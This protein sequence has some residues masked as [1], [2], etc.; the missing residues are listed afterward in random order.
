MRCFRT[1]SDEVYEQARLA[2]D[3]AWG[4]P[5]SATKTVT[6]IDP[7]GVATRDVQGRIMLAVQDAF[8]QYTVVSELLPQLLASGAVEEI[9]EADYMAALPQAPE[10]LPEPSNFNVVPGWPVRVR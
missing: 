2:L 4:H 10:P 8:C 1:S 3:A 6:C 7:V 9:T 5:N